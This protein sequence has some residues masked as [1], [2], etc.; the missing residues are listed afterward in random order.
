MCY[1]CGCG[2]LNDNMGDDANI[3]ES[4]LQKA[5]AA[6]G[7]NL[8]EAKKNIYDALKKQVEPKND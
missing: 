4:D 7:Q 1:N 6:M 3:T 5:A 2:R 8:D